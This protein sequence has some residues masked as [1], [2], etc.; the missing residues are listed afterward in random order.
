MERLGLIA[1][2]TV[3]HYIPCT[4]KRTFGCAEEK[5]FLSLK[6]KTPVLVFRFEF[7]PYFFY[8]RLIVSC[9]TRTNKEWRVLQDNGLCLYKN[10]AC[11]AYK[12]HAVALAVNPS[13]IQLQVFQPTNISVTK[14]VALEVRKIITHLLNDLLENYHKKI[15]MYTV[16]F[17]CSKQEVFHEHDDCFVKEEQ[18]LKEGTMLCPKHELNNSHILHESTLLFYWNQ[19]VLAESTDPDALV[20]NRACRNLPEPEMRRYRVQC[21]EKLTKSGRE[22]L[23]MYFD[24]VFPPAELFMLLQKNKENLRKQ[25]NTDQCDLLFPVDKSIP[26]SS[27]FDVTIMYKLLRNYGPNLP[28]PTKGWGKTPDPGQKSPTDDVERIRVYRNEVEHKTPATSVMEKEDCR[29]KWRDLCQAIL[30]LSEGSLEQDIM[31][32]IY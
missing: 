20:E 6:H 9:L 25:F 17:Q 11:F 16:G 22:A 19:D 8:F 15:D 31:E 26:T 21:F 12:L 23:Q 14:K 28:T 24:K 2:G 32:L 30:R 29:L 4:N 5:Y 13:S 3:A 18:L 1:V 27:A 7:L 10:V